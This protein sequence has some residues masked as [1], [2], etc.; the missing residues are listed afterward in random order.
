MSFKIRVI[1]NSAFTQLFRCTFD[2]ENKISTYKV[3]GARKW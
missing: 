3:G 1:K 2:I